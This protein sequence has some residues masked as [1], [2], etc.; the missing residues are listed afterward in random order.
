M[1]GTSTQCNKIVLLL[2]IVVL[3]YLILCKTDGFAS[4]VGG[5]N[6]VKKVTA[7]NFNNI[8]NRN[9]VIFLKIYTDWCG[10]CK[11]MLEPW[12]EL[13]SDVHN[14]SKFKGVVVAELDADKDKDLAQKLGAQG[15]PTIVVIKGGQVVDK[16]NGERT[17]P[18]MKTFLSKHV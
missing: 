9:D 7:N 5:G 4:L 15:F 12:K 2:I 1:A 18:A 3:M 14:D 17:A 16:Y 13:A 8:S 10:H 11:R 6:G